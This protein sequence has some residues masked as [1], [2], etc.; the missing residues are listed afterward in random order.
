MAESVKRLTQADGYAAGSTVFIGSAA[1]ILTALAFEHVG[2]YAPCPLCLIQRYAYYAA[3]PAS[4]VGLIAIAAQARMLGG[5][6]FLIVGLLYVANTGLGI[7]HSGIEWGFWPGPDTCDTA[8]Q[9]LAAT[10]QGLLQSL[11]ANA[12][13]SCSEAPFRF[14]MLSFAGWSA[15]ISAVFSALALST[16]NVNLD[17]G[18]R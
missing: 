11:Q 9:P 13:V 7:Y 12:V 8:A 17:V 4:F 6:I 5:V 3:V 16:A 18:R 10:T 1:A 2:G 14:L 15:A